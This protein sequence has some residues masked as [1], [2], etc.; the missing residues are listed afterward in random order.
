MA[1]P[2]AHISNPQT[3]SGS[4]ESL[5]NDQCPKGRRAQVKKERFWFAPI[6][7]FIKPI[8]LPLGLDWRYDV[9]II[10]SFLAREELVGIVTIFGTE[11]TDE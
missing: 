1:P 5:L 6:D 8:F 4:A 2:T 3:L 9:A 10:S 7:R 11:Y